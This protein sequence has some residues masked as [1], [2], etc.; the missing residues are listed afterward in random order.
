MKDLSFK[1][2]VLDFDIEGLNK[3]I[4]MGLLEILFYIKDLSINILDVFIL[5]G[6]IDIGFFGIGDIVLKWFRV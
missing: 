2:I 5:L 4:F 3:G 1:I 6:S